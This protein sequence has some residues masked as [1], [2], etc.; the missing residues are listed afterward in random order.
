MTHHRTIAE[1]YWAA[2]C[3]RDVEGV[4]RHYHEDARFIAPGWDLTGHDQ[5]RRY[6]QESARRFPGLE[7][8]VLRDLAQG[9]LGAVEWTA[10][11][12][13][14]ASV[15]HPIHGVNLIVLR[16]ERFAEVRAYF[17]VS[18]LGEPTS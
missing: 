4:L 8:T 9:D 12:T 13:D 6:Y 10:T 7:V 11:L 5:I 2:E 3:A 16:G 14:T 1:S 18:T 17:D 15:A